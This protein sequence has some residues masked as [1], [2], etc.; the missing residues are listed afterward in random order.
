MKKTF[1]TL[2]TVL[3]L[4]ISGT[5]LNAQTKKDVKVNDSKIVWKGYKVTGSHEGTIN[6]KSGSLTF[7]GDALTG[8]EFVV[9]MTS[10]EST[11][12]SGN[13]KG[14]LDGHLKQMIFLVLKTTLKQP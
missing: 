7:K 8:G 10:L 6:L 2:V 9:D 3:A 1:A 12:L 14:K 11:D 5:T 4:V 13:M